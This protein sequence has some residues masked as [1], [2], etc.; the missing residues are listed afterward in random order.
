VQGRAFLS[1]RTHI[2]NQQRATLSA[3]FYFAALHDITISKATPHKHTRTTVSQFLCCGCLDAAPQLSHSTFKRIEIYQTT[4]GCTRVSARRDSIWLRSHP[5]NCHHFMELN[6][7]T[8]KPLVAPEK[9]NKTF[10]PS[11]FVFKINL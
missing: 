11:I 3:A 5:G 4:G 2:R 7:S 6:F 9:R 10:F 8:N 1:T